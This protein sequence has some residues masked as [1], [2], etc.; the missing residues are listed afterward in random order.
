MTALKYNHQRRFALALKLLQDMEK[1]E[2]QSILCP[3]LLFDIIYET[4][5]R[6]EKGEDDE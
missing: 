2:Y 3:K 1:E 6:F 5:E 4:L